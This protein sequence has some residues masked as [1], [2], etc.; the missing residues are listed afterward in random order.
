MTSKSPGA[1]QW[2]VPFFLII[3]SVLTG[4]HPSSQASQGGE[5]RHEFQINLLEKQQ[6]TCSG[7]GYLHVN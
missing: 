5:V 3:L 2:N 7:S 1:K 6:E 4:N